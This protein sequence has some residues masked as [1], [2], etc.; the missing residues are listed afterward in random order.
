MDEAVERRQAFVASQ[1]SLDAHRLVFLDEASCSTGL[2]NNYGYAP[3]GVTPVIERPMRGERV[4]MLG[5]IALDG[6]RALQVV[7]DNVNGAVFKRFLDEVLGPTLRPGDVVVMDGPHVHRVA[8][9]VEILEKYGATP[10]YLP[11]YSPELNPIEMTWAWMKQQLRR[12]A[13]REMPK[14]RKAIDRLWSAITPALTTG[15]VRHA[16]YAEAA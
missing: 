9:V 2:S 16:G 14:V 1:P 12:A 5:A 3:P 13:F 7:D 6:V 15:W 8:G 10:L 4:T 11:A